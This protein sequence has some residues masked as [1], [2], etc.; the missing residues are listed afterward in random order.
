MVISSKL[1]SKVKN[2]SLFFTADLHFGHE[3]IL[4]FCKDTRCNCE[5]IEE[6]NQLLINNWNQQVKDDDTVYILGDFSFLKTEM[7]I[8]IIKQL[9]GKKHLIKG[10]HD[11]WAKDESLIEKYFESISDYKEIYFNKKL[12]VLF[13]YPIVE[14]R[15]MHYGSWHLFGHVHGKGNYEGKC[16]DIGIDALPT[17]DCKLW[18]LE[19]VEIYM[20]DKP[21][22]KH[23]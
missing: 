8:E 1:L 22:I 7:T 3:N 13:H 12:I 5:N 19:D 18:S 15:N 11:K 14:W 17:K 10:N 21:I 9:N 23:F 6:M 4:G 20:N 2:M 16:L